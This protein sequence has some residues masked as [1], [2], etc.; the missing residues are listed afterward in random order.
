M[1]VAERTWWK[2]EIQGPTFERGEKKQSYLKRWK[3]KHNVLSCLKLLSF[4]WPLEFG[5]QPEIAG[6]HIR[7]V[8]SLANHRSLVFCETKV[9]IKCEECAGAL[10]WWRRQLPVDHKWVSWATQHYIRDGGH[11]CS[12]LWWFL[13][14]WCVLLVYHNAGVKECSNFGLWKASQSIARYPPLCG[15]Y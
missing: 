3:S 7:W 15:H 1:S 4:Q 10:S 14:L 9:W 8:R 2:D 13:T 11:P 6:S 5:E 12:T